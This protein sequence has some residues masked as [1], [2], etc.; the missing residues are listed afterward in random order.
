MRVASEDLDLDSDSWIID[1]QMG[2]GPPLAPA[3][4][5]RMRPGDGDWLGGGGVKI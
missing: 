3:L 2:V 1:E 5:E 4:I